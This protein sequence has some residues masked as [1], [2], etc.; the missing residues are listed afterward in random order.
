M[1]KVEQHGFLYRLVALLS[2]L[3]MISLGVIPF[4]RGGDIFYKNW[5]GEL[6]FAPFA[7]L[8]G[9]FTIFC[10]IFKPDWLAARPVE[11]FGRKGRPHKFRRMVRWKRPGV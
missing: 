4:A 5:F 8:G 9:I 3:A 11:R 1:F 10:A 7:V 6:V 2:G